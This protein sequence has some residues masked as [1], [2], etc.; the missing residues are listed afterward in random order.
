MKSALLHRKEEEVLE[1]INRFFDR[2]KF[3]LVSQDLD[4]DN[5]VFQFKALK[6]QGLLNMKLKEGLELKIHRV[7][8]G[9]TRIDLSVLKNDLEV[10]HQNYREKEARLIQTIYKIF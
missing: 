2:K 3:K 8:D 9:I 5:G 10:D 7:S 1:R 4:H 6:K